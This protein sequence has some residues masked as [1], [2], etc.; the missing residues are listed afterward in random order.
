MIKEALE[1]LVKLGQVKTIEVNGQTYTTQDLA[2]ITLPKAE[3]LKVNS[4]TGLID[5]IKSSFDIVTFHGNLIHVVDHSEVRLISNILPDR[6]REVYMSAHA[7]QPEF[8]FGRFYDTE[9]FIILLQSCFV[10]NEDAKKILKLVGNIK[11][12]A[13]RTYGDDGITQS[14]TAKVGIAQVEEVA[15]PNP[16]TLAPYRTFVEVE[17]P[18]SKFVFR[19]RKG[20]EGP[21]AA[22][23]EADGGAWKI[24][25]M[26]RVKTFLKEKLA[27][28][29][30][31]I[32]A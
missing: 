31:D 4:L 10:Q 19:M 25:A 8:R 30:I 24:E 11:D 29:E 7:F 12:S 18:E 5:Y 6:G 20:E 23:F 16:V 1:Y 22:L 17:Q 13:V 27:L 9:S 3:T 32:I 2:R 26:Q 21:Q 14:V 15:V 28:Y